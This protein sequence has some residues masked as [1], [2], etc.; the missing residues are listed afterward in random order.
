M[1]QPGLQRPLRLLLHGW[2]GGAKLVRPLQG[3]DEG[4]GLE[5]DRSDLVLRVL[6]NRRDRAHEEGKVKASLPSSALAGRSLAEGEEGE[7][8]D[9][10]NLLPHPPALVLEL[11]HEGLEDLLGA[12]DL[13]QLHQHLDV[14]LPDHGLVVCELPDEVGHQKMPEGLNVPVQQ[15]DDVAKDLQGRDLDLEV[16][17]SREGDE[18]V[19][20]FG[21]VRSELVR[22]LEASHNLLQLLN[23]QGSDS[24]VPHVLQL[25]Q[26]PGR[27]ERKRLPLQLGRL[28]RVGAVGGSSPFEVSSAVRFSARHVRTRMLRL[29]INRS[30]Q[31]LLRR[32]G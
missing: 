10:E 23:G 26:Q 16:G 14:G 27:D 29:A 20:Q 19:D 17:V 3:V 11:H 4:E 13:H 30:M 1:R 22:A 7:D 25:S 31:H 18:Q 15:V 28:V 24:P 21:Q 12:Q 5:G 9:M 2:E 32:R 8:Y 6:Q